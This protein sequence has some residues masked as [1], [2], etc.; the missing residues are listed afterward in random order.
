MAAGY[1]DDVKQVPLHQILG[2]KFPDYEYQEY[3]KWVRAKGKDAVLVQGPVDEAQ[4]W[5]DWGLEPPPKAET[6]AELE[7]RLRKEMEAEIREALALEIEAKV[8]HELAQK[9]ES[10][11]G[12]TAGTASA[13]AGTFKAAAPAGA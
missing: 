4:V 10:P 1:K 8:R 7:V 3:P 5:K 13:P 12:S 9:V 6:Q 2:H 11:Q